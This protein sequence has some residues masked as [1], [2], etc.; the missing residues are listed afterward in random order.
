MLEQTPAILVVDSGVGAQAEVMD[1]LIG[2]KYRVIGATSFQEA[3]MLLAANA[4]DLLI[5]ELRLEA[6][7]GL[8]LVI[9]ARSCHAIPAIVVTSFHDPVL[10]TEAKLQRAAYF[11]K[12]LRPAEFLTTV[13]RMLAAL[14]PP[15]R[16]SEAHQASDLDGGDPASDGRPSH[17]RR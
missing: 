6:F 5:T 16:S 2:A 10:E 1:L 15:P 8:Q 9:C 13:S 12:P 4:P 11:V 17:P 14:L 3:K 7:N